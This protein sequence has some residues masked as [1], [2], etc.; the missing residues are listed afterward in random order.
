MLIRLRRSGN[1]L[2]HLQQHFKL[3]TF[4]VPWILV[5]LIIFTVSKDYFSNQLI[6]LPNGD[7]HCSLWRRSWIF[8]FDA[9]AFQ[10]SNRCWHNRNWWLDTSYLSNSIHQ[11]R[12]RPQREALFT[13]VSVKIQ[14]AN[15]FE[16]SFSL[17]LYIVVW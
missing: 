14:T 8:V 5:Y 9:G 15:A 11:Q 1:C 3:C 4:P 6:C 2:Y 17:P 16:A 10:S 12:K 13:S 7:G